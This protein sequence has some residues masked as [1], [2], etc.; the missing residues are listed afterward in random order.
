MFRHICTLLFLLAFLNVP[1][2]KAQTTISDRTIGYSE[3]FDMIEQSSDSLIMFQDITLSF[4][5]N[6]DRRFL[7]YPYSDA[8][9]SVD[10]IRVRPR[11]IFNRIKLDHYEGQQSAVYAFHHIVWENDVEFYNVQARNLNLINSTFRKNLSVYQ[12]NNE[13]KLV[14]LRVSDSHFKSEVHVEKWA[15]NMDDFTF[16]N[17]ST[18]STQQLPL[19]VVFLDDPMEFM[20]IRNNTISS[21]DTDATIYIEARTR[22]LFLIRDNTFQVNVA[23]TSTRTEGIFILFNNEYDKYITFQ[24]SHFSRYDT[25]I[26]WEEVKDK[27]VFINLPSL[28]N[29][30]EDYKKVY[31]EFNTSEDFSHPYAYRTMIPVYKMLHEIFLATE[32]RRTANDLY[33]KLKK[34]EKIEAEYYYRNNPSFATYF[35][36]QLYRF[37]DTFSDFGTRPAKGIIISIYVIL[38][39]SVVYFLFPN[40]WDSISKHKIKSRIVF[41]VTYFQHEKSMLQVYEDKNKNKIESYDTFKKQLFDLKG[42][43]PGA[44]IFLARPVYLF[45][46]LNYKITSL[47]LKQVDFVKVKWDEQSAVRK[48]ISSIFITLGL[49][50][51]VVYDVF[52]KVLNAVILSINTFTTLGFGD[53]PTSGIPRYMA[54][55]EGF[56]G[57]FMLTFFS[58]SL[59]WQVL[60]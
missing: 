35:D 14:G 4:N 24:A 45:S 49:A 9:A 11:V 15:N 13:Y 7:F 1:S 42:K 5:P 26:E 2:L 10:S 18:V 32:P 40:S 20:E 6:Q 41:F 31:I 60:N 30:Y 3:L 46:I 44:V 47:F 39:F 27:L 51:L 21:T 48:T 34:I 43:V 8:N 50:L 36:W 53:I 29:Y 52:I 58:V 37:I 57:W 59:I 12:R 17:N 28:P 25:R 33:V 54:V 16:S 19:R 56:V 22:N 23:I 38:L 55:I